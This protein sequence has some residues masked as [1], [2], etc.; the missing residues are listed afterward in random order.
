MKLSIYVVANTPL[1]RLHPVVKVVGIFC[2]FVAAFTAGSPIQSLPLAAVVGALL[3]LGGALANVWR[4][5]WFLA[6]VFFMTFLV[7]SLFFHSEAP[8]FAWGPVRLGY[9]G[10]R[11]ALATA[12]RLTTFFAVGLLFLSTTRVEEF[13]DALG[14]IGV[15]AKLGFVMTLAFRLV[16]AFVDAALSV[17]QAQ[18]CRGFDFDRGNWLERVR[19]YLPVI[20]PVFIGALRRADLMAMA[21][22]ARGFQLPGPR[23]SYRTYAWGWGDAIA[24]VGS[25]MLAG[26]W[27][28]WA[29]FAGGN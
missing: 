25:V 23:T 17:V 19:H 3:W 27:L 13:A 8:W 9:D 10:V 15:P 18:R 29:R 16:P 1:H 12:C 24:L 20:V 7:W 22:E 4:F 14:M 2:F 11:F 21:L 26:T 6:L 5:R 28:L